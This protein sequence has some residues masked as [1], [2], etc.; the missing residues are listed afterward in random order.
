MNKV[1]DMLCRLCGLC[2]AAT[3]MDLTAH[4][5]AL[6]VT[7]HQVTVA[8]VNDA[9]VVEKLTTLPAMSRKTL[10]SVLFASVR[11]ATPYDSI[12]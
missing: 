4:T 11:M 12:S 5:S 6:T 9:Q 3:H 2:N 10:I 8:L 7:L 1:R